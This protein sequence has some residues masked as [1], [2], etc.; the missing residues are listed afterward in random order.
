MVVNS[1]TF[2]GTTRRSSKRKRFDQIFHL[3]R[4]LAS[5]S[6]YLNILRRF[7][8]IFHLRLLGSLSS[9]L[10][11]LRETVYKANQANEGEIISASWAGCRTLSFGRRASCTAKRS[12]QWLT[13]GSVTENSAAGFS[14]KIDHK[15]SNPNTSAPKTLIIKTNDS[16]MSYAI[17]TWS[18]DLQV[19]PSN[20]SVVRGVL[21]TNFKENTRTGFRIVPTM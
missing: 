18:W 19:E 6:S 2:C 9:Y 21:R 4:L 1:T 5:L 7:D 14:A 11:L 3:V 10:N 16:P 12:G 8:Q 17:T 13:W 20:S 15:N